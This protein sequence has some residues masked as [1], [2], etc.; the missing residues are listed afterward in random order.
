MAVVVATQFRENYGAHEWDGTGTCPQYWKNKFGEDYI[1]QNA[2]SEEDA[3]YFVDHH[4]CHSTNYSQEWVISSLEVPED[5]RT[6][7]EETS[8]GEV[9]AIRIDWVDRFE[10]RHAAKGQW[11]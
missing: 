7:M 9:P 3:V 1:I 4:I 11:S 10:S 8:N 2:P 6:E 5:H